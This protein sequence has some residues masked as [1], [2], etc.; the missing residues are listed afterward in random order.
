MTIESASL[1]TRPILG[2]VQRARRVWM[3]TYLPV[4]FPVV[5]PTFLVNSPYDPLFAAT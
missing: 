2:L 3:G 4:P 5:W 1:G